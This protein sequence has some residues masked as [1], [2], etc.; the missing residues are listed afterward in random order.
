MFAHDKPIYQQIR[1]MIVTEIISG[2][3]KEEE[4][5]PSVRTLSTEL[6]VNPNTVLRT[7]NELQK[8]GILE[9]ERGMGNR[10]VKGAAGRL[11]R[12]LKKRFEEGEMD[13]F[14]KQARLLGFT[15][16]TLCKTIE[17]VWNNDKK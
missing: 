2:R 12:E 16:E 8:D 9:M 3:W 5:I 6:D 11:S 17:R 13:G 1:E 14:I 15:K 4:F 10:V 7:L